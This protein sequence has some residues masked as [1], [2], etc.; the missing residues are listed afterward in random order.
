MTKPNRQEQADNLK[1]LA[2]KVGI[3]WNVNMTDPVELSRMV[4]LSVSK[5]KNLY[6]YKP[7]QTV[8]DLA[9][10]GK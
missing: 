10:F 3:D 4:Y 6:G 2:L 5:F 9:R 1:A 7:T 8:I